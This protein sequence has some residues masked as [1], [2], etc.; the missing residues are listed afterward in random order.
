MPQAKRDE[1]HPS[2]IAA[3]EGNY[4]QIYNMGNAGVNVQN[5]HGDTPAHI[6]ILRDSIKKDKENVKYINVLKAVCDEGADLN[7]ANDRGETPLLLA[8]Q[9][10]N[11]S[12][13]DVLMSHLD[14]VN[15][16]QKSYGKDLEMTPLHLASRTGNLAFI[17]KLIKSGADINAQDSNGLTPLMY[18]VREGHKEVVELLIKNGA[19][20]AIKS[21]ANMT[22]SEMA[23]KQSDKDIAAEISKTPPSVL[24]SS[25]FSKHEEPQR[26][27]QSNEAVQRTVRK[28]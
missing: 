11:A 3:M 2:I 21:K 28:G 12:A 15:V 18:A 26:P 8:I 4:M 7:I 1:N 17:D 13:F 23:L 14:K 10:N 5:L 9:N 6:A 16:N 24:K 19:D 25:I 20:P 27:L 22:A